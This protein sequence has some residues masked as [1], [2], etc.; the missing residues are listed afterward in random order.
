[1][2]QKRGRFIVMSVKVLSEV[3]DKSRTVGNARLILLALADCASEDGACWPSLNKLKKKAG[4][5]K[6]TVRKY[7][8]AFEA[9]NLIE[10]E[11]R[12]DE[13]GRRTSNIYKIN[14]EKLG[15]DSLSR[16]ILNS[17]IPKSKRREGVGMNP[18]TVW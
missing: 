14:L 15:D 11:D 9:I 1:M 7:L 6:E 8:H 16:K 10:L 4:V 17:V 18:F 2:R 13:R 3:F 5:S 12:F